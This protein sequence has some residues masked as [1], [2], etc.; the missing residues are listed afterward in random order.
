MPDRGRR[1]RGA[2]ACPAAHR[3]HATPPVFPPVFALWHRRRKPWELAVPVD[4]A[5]PCATQHEL[6]LED[7]KHLVG[8][9]GLCWPT[10]PG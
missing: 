2:C 1:S 7:A 3:T 6:T 8:V 9:K 10:K 4:M 5:F